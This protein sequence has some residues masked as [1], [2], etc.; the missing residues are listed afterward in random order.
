MEQCFKRGSKG[1]LV[2]GG[3]GPGV[4]SVDYRNSSRALVLL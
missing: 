4:A 1:C 2:S 3:V